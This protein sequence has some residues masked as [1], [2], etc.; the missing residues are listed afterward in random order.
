MP[1]P[2]TSSAYGI[3]S[4]NEVRDAERGDNW[5]EIPPEIGDVY[6]GGI[7]AGQINDDGVTYN[8]ILAPKSLGESSQDLEFKT[9][10]TATSGTA[11]TTNGPANTA[12]IISA[13]ASSHPAANFCN[14][15]SIGG[16]TDW[17]LPAQD[18]LEVVYYNLKPSTSSN[19]TNYGTNTNAVPPRNSNYT[20]GNPTQTSVTAFQAGNTEDFRL[21]NYRS[22]TTAGDSTAVSLSF[23]N[24]RLFNFPKDYTYPVRAMRRVEA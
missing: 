15:L 6:Q 11:S 5:P 13:G 17:Y 10:N 23:G 18:E 21:T 1:H 9:S 12:A 2:S 20:V 14:N 3:W 8:L 19:D 4:L 7:F 24:G 16:F 22:S